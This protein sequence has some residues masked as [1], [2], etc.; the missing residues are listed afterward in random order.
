MS[1]PS[2]C[3]RMQTGGP[4][5][6]IFVWMKSSQQLFPQPQH[7]APTHLWASPSLYLVGKTALLHAL[8]SS[9]GVQIH[10]TDNIRLL[11]EGGEG[12]RLPTLQLLLHPHPTP[13]IVW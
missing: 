10:N 9:D 4:P 3:V 13:T 7:P 6:P 8:A 2:F 12:P 1:V 11:L 5:V